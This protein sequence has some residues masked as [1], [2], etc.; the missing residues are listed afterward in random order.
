MLGID[1]GTGGVRAALFDLSGTLIGI[2]DR[3][4]VTTYPQAGWAEQRPDDWWDALVGAV[5]E[6]AAVSGIDA[7]RII[8]LAVD[9]PCDILLADAAG[10]PLTNALM[11]MD[12]RAAD[13]ARRLTETGAA[14]LRY[15]G[16]VVPAEWPLPKTLWLKEHAAEVWS[17]ADRLVEQMTWLTWRLTGEWVAPL[18]SAAAKWHYR[19]GWPAELMHAVGLD[20]AIEKLPKTAVPMGGRGGDLSAAAAQTS[21]CAPASPSR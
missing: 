15:C 3:A 11:W 9:A 6:V 16:G 17:R 4:Y 13:Q 5:H 10:E 1:A 21:A 20:E 12:L 8:G 7:R 14:V 19:G 2:A 18:N